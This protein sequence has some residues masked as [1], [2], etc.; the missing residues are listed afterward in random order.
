[1][2]LAWIKQHPQRVW[3]IIL[4]VGIALFGIHWEEQPFIEY[5]FLPALGFV[6]I[7][8]GLLFYFGNYYYAHK[9]VPSL[10]PKVLWVPLVVIVLF[11]ALRVAVDPSMET[12]AGLFFGIFMIA[13]YV[14]SREVGRDMLLAFIPFVMIVAVSCVVDGITNPGEATGGMIANYCASTGFMIFGTIVNRFRWQWILAT[15][16]LVALFFTGA[17]EAV[18]IMIVLGITLL[19]RRDWGRKTLLPVG[20][21]AIAVIVGLSL[22]YG[23][24]SSGNANLDAIS[25]ILAGNSVNNVMLNDL[26]TDRWEQVE[27]ALSNVSMFGHGFEPGLPTWRTVHNLPMVIVDQIGVIPG[28]AWLFVTLYCLIRTRWRYA[29]IAILAMSVFDHYLWTQF[30][31]FWWMLVGTST[32]VAVDSD[33]IFRRAKNET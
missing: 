22:G 28:L 21:A 18:F 31:P 14:A 1:M 23:F 8:L 15:L 19:I 13:I 26:T 9:A 32:T 10:G 5:L 3:A 4:G 25:T 11:I 30:A 29:W 20:L 33:L 24:P 6:I 17:L 16:V 2:L 7:I 27:Y 12:L